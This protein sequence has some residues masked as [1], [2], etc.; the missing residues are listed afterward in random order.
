M[1]DDGRGKM[2]EG[3]RSS[4]GAKVTRLITLIHHIRNVS[5]I[6]FRCT[7]VSYMVRIVALPQSFSRTC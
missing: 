7:Y 2:R 4:S 3:R 5:T 6:K 1:G